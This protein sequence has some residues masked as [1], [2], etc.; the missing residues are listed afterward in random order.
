VEILMSANNNARSVTAQAFDRA[1]LEANFRV[2]VPVPRGEG[3][4]DWV[5]QPLTEAELAAMRHSVDRGTPYGTER[6]QKM[7]AVRLGLES[8]PRGRPRKPR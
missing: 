4:L 6:W 2:A 7:T 8:R 1:R 5:N 3:W